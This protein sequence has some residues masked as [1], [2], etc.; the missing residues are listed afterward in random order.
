MGCGEIGSRSPIGADRKV[1]PTCAERQTGNCQIRGINDATQCNGEPGQNHAGHA[2]HSPSGGDVE[3][4]CESIGYPSTQ[5]AKH[6]HGK[7][8]NGGIESTAEHI[9]FS[10]IHEIEVEPGE[11]DVG[12]IA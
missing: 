11:I 5:G 6:Q 10:N 1:E 4:G 2:C 8:G 12:Y 7:K 9:E 3:A